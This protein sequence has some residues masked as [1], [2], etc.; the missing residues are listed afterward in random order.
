[1]QYLTALDIAEEL[2]LSRSRA[3]EIIKECNRIVT[4]RV[5]RVSRPAFEAWKRRHEHP[6]DSEL[7]PSTRSNRRSIPVATLLDRPDWAALEL[8]A[9]R[10]RIKKLPSV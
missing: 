2:K 9:I 3:Y 10:P 5:S 1:M 7:L 4:G 8:A 6:P